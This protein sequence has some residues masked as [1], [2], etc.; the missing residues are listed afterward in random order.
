[1][2][3]KIAIALCCLVGAGM[4][5]ARPADEEEPRAGKLHYA[6]SLT[7]NA[8]KGDFAPYYMAANRN[9]TLTQKAGAQLRAGAFRPLELDKRFSWSVGV[10]VLSGVSAYTDYL[11]YDPVSTDWEKNRQQPAAFWLQQLY[12]KLKWRQVFLEVGMKE[13]A[14]ALFNNRLGSGDFVESGN[15]RPIPGVRIGFIDFQDIP[16]TKGTLQIQ[17]EIAYGKTTDK[18]WLQD[19]Y[20]RY[21]NFV[22]VDAW[23]HYKRLYF[24]TAPDKPL[25]VTFGMQAAAQFAGTTTNYNRGKAGSTKKR[26]FQLRDLW[27]MLIT[28]GEDTY[29]KGNH[30]GAWDLKAVY[31][32]RG[33]SEV[34]GY[35][36]WPWEDGSGI[37]KLNGFDGIWGLEWKSSGRHVVNGTVAEFF[38]FM[39]QSGP[40]HYDPEDLG[41]DLPEH[42]DGSD[43][44]Y[45]NYQYNGYAHHGMGIGSPLLPSTL[46]NIDGY[47]RYVDTRLRGFHV[48]LSGTLSDRLDYRLLA[49]YR[50]GFGT[51]YFPRKSPVHDTSVLLE[52]T[53]R[54]PRVSGLT[55]HAQ[56]AADWGTIYGNQCGALLGIAY[57]GILGL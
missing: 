25:S 8:G 35:F 27:D 24:R 48:G 14:S 19:H 33:G 37:G 32:L 21:N 20:N 16:F 12:G 54:V 13:R 53:W 36:Q 22:T 56:V 31:R 9:G 26:K 2:N 42:T 45:N 49:G 17:G 6:V 43:D 40:L 41:S 10:D 46:Y 55:V 5:N 47:M 23:Y 44:Y 29:Y 1:M 38:T 3:K 52:A 30:L 28:K 50:K 39:N 51:A 18:N 57:R 11:R 7:T 4:T 15:A 34:V